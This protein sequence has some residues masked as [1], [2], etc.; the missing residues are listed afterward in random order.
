[1]STRSPSKQDLNQIIASAGDK[2]CLVR[3]SASQKVKKQRRDKTLH[4]MSF[5]FN[6]GVGTTSV[7]A[8][9]PFGNYKQLTHFVASL[10]K[11]YKDLNDPEYC[12]I[13]LETTDVYKDWTKNICGTIL[14]RYFQEKLDD[15]AGWIESSFKEDYLGHD[16]LELVFEGKRLLTLSDVHEVLKEIFPFPLKEGFSVSIKTKDKTTEASVPKHDTQFVF[17]L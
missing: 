16:T 11:L 9:L 2:R 7:F 13:F 3:R 8:K 6:D 12:P 10:Q 1:M 15:E 5:I 4:S 14:L 17:C